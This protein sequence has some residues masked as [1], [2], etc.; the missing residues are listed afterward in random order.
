LHE[1]LGGAAQG[2]PHIAH[3]KDFQKSYLQRLQKALFF[4]HQQ[5]GGRLTRQ[6]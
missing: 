6:Q 3:L 4:I 2:L 1:L 5:R